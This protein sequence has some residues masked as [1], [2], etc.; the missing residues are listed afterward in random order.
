MKDE[1]KEIIIKI[2][3]KSYSNIFGSSLLSESDK[4]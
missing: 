3:N 4:E 2:M 1:M